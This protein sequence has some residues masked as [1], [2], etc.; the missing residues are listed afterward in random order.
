[1]LA[2]LVKGH[3]LARLCLEVVSAPNV[4]GWRGILHQQEHDL[5]PPW[6][7][8]KGEQAEASQ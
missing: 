7:S 5:R 6:L 2:Q 4:D 8:H 1:M 3:I